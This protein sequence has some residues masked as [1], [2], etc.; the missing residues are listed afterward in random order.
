MVIP[1]DKANEMEGPSEEV[2]QKLAGPEHPGRLR[3]MGLGPT[4]S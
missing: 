3:C 4:Q 1:M 2:F